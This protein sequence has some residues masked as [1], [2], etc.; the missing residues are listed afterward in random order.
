MNDSSTNN[1]Y[2][3]IEENKLGNQYIEIGSGRE[4]IV[5]KYNDAL[6]IKIFKKDEIDFSNI[7]ERLKY[8]IDTEIKVNNVV[9]PK[10]VVI[11]SSNEILGYSMKLIKFNKYKSFFNL[12]ECKNNEEFIN[13]FK[14]IQDTMK[15]LHKNNIFI[16]DFNPNNIMI[17][18]DNKPLFIDT[19]NYATEKYGFLHESYNS[20]IYEKLFKEKCS[21]LDND[22]FMFSF[23]FLTFFISFEDL[24]IAI[25]DAN[26]F[27]IIIEK[28]DI[29]NSS[30]Q[31][32]NKIFSTENNKDYLD[33]IFEEFKKKEHLKFDNKFGKIMKRL[34]K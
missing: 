21:K 14:Q 15:E 7:R 18:K 17:D 9:F 29:S 6:A 10:H 8:L 16:G 1:N 30:K 31:I 12:Y 25:K 20:L 2:I 13:Y 3:I 4:G 23:L 22:K 27:K 26:Y 32:L 34:F 5:Y 19:I 33:E 28:L 11:N 24:E